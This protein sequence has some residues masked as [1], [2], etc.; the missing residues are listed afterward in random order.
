MCSECKRIICP[1]SCPNYEPKAKHYCS[2][3]EEGI[4][5]GEEYVKNDDD[6][7]RHYDCFNGMRDLLDWLGYKLETMNGDLH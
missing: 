1:S 7:Y 3:C 6:E 4:Y 2:I 5:D